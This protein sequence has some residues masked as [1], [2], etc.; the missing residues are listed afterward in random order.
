MA[1]SLA[2]SV[3][4]LNM[5]A[6]AWTSGFE[7]PSRFIV[8]GEIVAVS[9]ANDSATKKPGS[10]TA[11]SLTGASGVSSTTNPADRFTFDTAEMLTDNLTR[12]LDC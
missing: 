11:V 9:L 7:L 4:R 1:G 3:L 8:D 5:P 12:T 10:L 6:A 2:R